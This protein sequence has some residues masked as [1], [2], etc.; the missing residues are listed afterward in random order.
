MRG[1]AIQESKKAP[2]VIAYMRVSTQQQALE[3]LSLVAQR[4]AIEKYCQLRGWELVCTCHDAGISGKSMDNRP[5]LQRALGFLR[6]RKADCLV[7]LR[8]DRL[9]RS[10]ADFTSLLCTA[11]REHWTITSISENLESGS[12]QGKLTTHILMALAEHERVL[13]SART[14]DGMAVLKEQGKLRGA[15]PYGYTL[16]S[17]GKTLIPNPLEQSTVRKIVALRRKKGVGFAVIATILNAVATPARGEKF[18]PA[19]VWS[20][21]NANKNRTWEGPDHAA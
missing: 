19:T 13:I 11:E 3:G 5:G 4:D 12:A 18:Y 9:S 15:V 6:A 2:R 7:V 14:S 1:A 17:D 16:N 10:L 20:I 8:L 21:Y